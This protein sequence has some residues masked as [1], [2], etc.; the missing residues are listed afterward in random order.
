MKRL[1]AV[2]IAAAVVAAMAGV[3]GAQT[4]AERLGYPAGAKV[5][6]IHCDDAGM[7]HSSTLGAQQSIERGVV[8]STS[9]MAPCPWVPMMAAWVKE[10]PTV[11]VGAHLAM[12]SEHD[13][14]RWPP[15]AGRSAVPGLTDPNGCLWDNSEEVVKHAT[16]DEVE[17]EIRAQIARLESYG[18]KLTH[19]DTHM[20]T[21]YA[22]PEFALRYVKV[23]I[24]KGLPIMAFWHLD[25]GDIP[26]EQMP[27]FQAMMK[28]VWDGGLPV[29]DNMMDDPYGAP[30][31]DKKGKFVEL[32]KNI[33]PGVNYLLVHCAVPSAE[34][35]GVNGLSTASR[36]MADLECMTDPEIKQLIKD[37]GIIL[38]TWRELKERRDK[39]GK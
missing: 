30:V 9:I 4:W 6:L 20:G 37:E 38:T 15:V 29:L 25:S 11:D 34:Q 13:N 2:L 3:A 14:Y 24:E 33:K 10:H 23:G 26:Q 27:M 7:S 32:L 22:K 1:T 39:V 18:I 19:I 16:P 21:L 8:T 17:A 35:V 36:W 5:L 31:A 12:C 28:Q